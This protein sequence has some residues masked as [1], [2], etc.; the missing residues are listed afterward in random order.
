M[1]H[2]IT[3]FHQVEPHNWGHVADCASLESGLPARHLACMNKDD[4]IHA[5]PAP[6]RSIAM[7]CGKCSRKLHGGFGKKRKHDLA[8]ALKGALREAGRRR[9][10]RVVEVGCFGLCPKR[11]VTAVSSAQPAE[12]LT[13][14]EG[15]DAAVVLA[16]LMP[17]AAATP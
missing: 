13:I 10:L 1:R 15:M 2:W 5:V 16:R 4:T 17:A 14:P 12:M 11:A 3:S 8:D 7:V 9:E 6:W